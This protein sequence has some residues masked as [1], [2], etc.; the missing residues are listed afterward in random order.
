MLL[1]GFWLAIT[2]VEVYASD[3]VS[4]SSVTVAE[5]KLVVKT[6]KDLVGGHV[7]V[8]NSNDVLVVVQKMKKR[9]LTIDFSNV[10]FGVYTIRIVKGE[11]QQEYH[12]LKK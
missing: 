3:V 5:T 8:Y 10:V 6:G 1:T 4:G 7:L 9:K 12:F 2:A 11:E